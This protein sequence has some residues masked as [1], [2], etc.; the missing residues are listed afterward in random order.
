VSSGLDSTT[1]SDSSLKSLADP[2]STNTLE[3]EMQ[4]TLGETPH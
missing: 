3:K 1:P 4:T 2:S